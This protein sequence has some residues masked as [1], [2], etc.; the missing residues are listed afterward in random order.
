MSVT[1]LVDCI[2]EEGYYDQPPSPT[3]SQEDTPPLDKEAFEGEAIEEKGNLWKRE[4]SQLKRKITVKTRR[5]LCKRKSLKRA[6]L[7]KR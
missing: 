7:K 4:V 3:A 6:L 1:E 2:R 5:S